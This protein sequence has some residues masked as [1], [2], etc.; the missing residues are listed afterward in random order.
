[1]GRIA[2]RAETMKNLP[3]AIQVLEQAAKE[4]G[5]IYVNRAAKVDDSLNSVPPTSVRVEVVDA[6]KRDADA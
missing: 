6:R 2:E 3:L 5:D 4:V 1:M